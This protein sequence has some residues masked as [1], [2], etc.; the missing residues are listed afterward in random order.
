MIALLK[1]S[2]IETGLITNGEKWT[3]VNAVEGEPTSHGTWHARL[4]FQEPKTF[5]TFVGLLRVARFYGP[6][7]VRLPFLFRESRNHQSDVTDT[8]GDQVA[9][10]I[11]VLIRSLDR[12]DDDR[13][14][15]TAW[16]KASCPL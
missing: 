12:A 16:H 4:W 1:A 7:N 2:K 11:E 8:L 15:N 13:T 9:R 3:L 5:Q 10:A 6:E 14:V